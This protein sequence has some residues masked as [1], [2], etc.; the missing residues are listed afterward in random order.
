MSEPASGEVFD[1]E[2]IPGQLFPDI[3]LERVDVDEQA[4]RVVCSD[5]D[6]SIQSD[7]TLFWGPGT[8]VFEVEG[9]IDVRIREGERWPLVA[10]ST[11]QNKLIPYLHTLEV[12]ERGDPWR[13][14][15]R[16]GDLNA[17]VELQSTVTR[18]TWHPDGA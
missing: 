13:L 11:A 1:L 5:G 10:P 17:K 4:I 12:I 6:W 9:D 7:I 3:E 8:M 18:I 15:F 14:R 16:A 2:W